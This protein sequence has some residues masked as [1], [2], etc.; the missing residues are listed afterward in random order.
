MRRLFWVALGATLGALVFRKLSRAA[1]K[2][3]PQGVAGSIGAGLSELGY[4]LR[5]FAADI[6]EAMS[7]Q[8][9]ALR[10]AA[11]LDSGSVSSLSPGG[12]EAAAGAVA[13]GPAGDVAAAV[14]PT[15]DRP[16]AGA[17]ERRAFDD[18]PSADA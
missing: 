17:P 3:T 5:E 10:A 9:A 12:A 6:R 16:A 13:P 1:Q 15:A 18:R 11:G 2:L 4:S 14:S 8:E 7:S